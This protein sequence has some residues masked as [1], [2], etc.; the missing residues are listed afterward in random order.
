MALFTFRFQRRRVIID[1]YEG[2]LEFDTEEEAQDYADNA[3]EATV[4]ADF[5]EVSTG[6]ES[7]DANEIV[8]LDVQEAV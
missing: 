2:A 1:N 4:L 8:A 6:E 7:D 5:I 3:D